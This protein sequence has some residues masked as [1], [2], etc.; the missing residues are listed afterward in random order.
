MEVAKLAGT[1]AELVPD[2]YTY[3]VSEKLYGKTVGV[4]SGASA[5]E[6]LVEALINKLSAPVEILKLKDE[7]VNFKLPEMNK[8]KRPALV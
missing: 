1:P 8:L 7:N 2:P 6:T 3:Q 5:P 4:S